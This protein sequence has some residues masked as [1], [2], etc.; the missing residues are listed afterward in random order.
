MKMEW[1]V[2]KDESEL[3]EIIKRSE[4]R[5]Q[6]IFK[7]STRCSISAVAKS[8]LDKAK[9]PENV[10]FYYLDLISFRNISNKVAEVFDVYHESP[11]VLVIRNG[12]CVYDESHMGISMQEI[13]T[14]A[15]F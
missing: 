2:I 4:E 8:R 10:D 7:H 6:V 13:L 3:E 15:E 11:Q 14:Y 1:K 9:A 5:P 12:E